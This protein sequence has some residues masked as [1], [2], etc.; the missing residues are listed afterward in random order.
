MNEE[1][2]KQ[3]DSSIADMKNTGTRAAGSATAACFLQRF[4]DKG[5]QWAHI[6][7]AGMDMSDGS[8]TLYPK[9]ASGFGVRLIN[10]FIRQIA[11]EM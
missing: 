9:G 10:R 2:N 7:I 4:I 6:D 8:K 3:M 11:Q 5:T 1:Y